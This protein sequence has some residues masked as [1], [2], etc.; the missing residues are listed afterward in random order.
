MLREQKDLTQLYLATVVGVTTDTISRWENRRYPSIKVENARKL[1][2]ALGV[3]LEELLEDKDQQSSED[4]AVPVPNHE[5]FSFFTSRYG[6]FFGGAGI[7]LL[8]VVI[9]LL[10]TTGGDLDTKA[11]RIL[12]NHASYHLPFPVRIEITGAKDGLQTLLIREELFGDCLA[13]GPSE[14]D[15]PKQYGTTPRWIG[16]LVKGRA[17]FLYKVQ[18]LAQPEIHAGQEQ[19]IRFSGDFL[20]REGQ[21]V[22]EKIGGPDTITLTPYHWADIDQDYVISDNEILLAYETFS[23]PGENLINFAAIEELWL[24]GGYT[25]DDRTLSFIPTRAE[26]IHSL[27]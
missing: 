12:P 2:D 6:L 22:G 17:T 20:F 1:A 18:P 27:E 15:S 25:W 7:A 19:I 21:T 23:V 8:G 14:G 26:H 13:I 16:T 4:R 9:F 11:T 5:N 10:L 24:A 3:T